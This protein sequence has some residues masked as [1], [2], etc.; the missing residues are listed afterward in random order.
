M[1]WL[2]LLA[3]LTGACIVH[4]PLYCD[5]THPCD[6]DPSLNF[7]DLDGTYPASEGHG[8]TCIAS[9]FD[10]GMPPD[11]GCTN[12]ATRNCGTDEGPCEF[13]TETCRMDGTWGP[14][15]GG[16]APSTETC[17]MVDDDC[18]SMVDEELGLGNACDGSD[19]DLCAEGTIVCTELGATA[20]TDG[21]GDN[22]EVCN[23]LDDD[24]DGSFDEAFNLQSDT[25]HCGDCEFACINES[26]TTYCGGGL[27]MPTCLLGAQDCDSN[28]INGC[29]LR[30]SNPTCPSVPSAAINGDSTA[31]PLTFS[32]FSEAWYNVH[33]QEVLGAPLTP[34]TASI[35]L[36]NP[37]GV[38]FD[39]FVYCHAC[40]ASLARSST[41][42]AGVTDSVF[43]GRDDQAGVDVSFD[44]LIEVR[45]VGANMCGNWGLTVNGNVVTSDRVCN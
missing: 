30:D 35:E 15:L 7:C 10:A 36:T 17:N 4:D 33:V 1:A 20:C 14:C 26:G 2:G 13:G 12:G 41:N 34:L 21:T 5:Q 6:K 3:V 9:P 44:I 11:A 19:T 40:G 24:C 25:N 29:E 16:T 22:P 18:D 31:V 32:G 43:I 38:D 45:Y 37:T 8:N 39:L 42:G 23:G 27:C 28:P